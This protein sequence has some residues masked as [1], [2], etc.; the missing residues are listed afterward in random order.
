[1][2]RLTHFSQLLLLRKFLSRN[3]IHSQVKSVRRLSLK[4]HHTFKFSDLSVRLASPDELHSKPDVSE[5]QF[6][7][8]FTDHMLKVAY[9]AS[10]GGWQKP[11]ITP[12]ENLVLH[13]AAKVLHYAIE[14]FEGMKAYRGVDDKIRLFR[15][16]L[17]MRRMNGSAARTSLP[18]FDGDELIRCLCR[19]ILIDQEW[20]PHSEAS[21]LYIRPTIIGIDPTLGVATSTSALLYAIMCPV[22]SY[23]GPDSKAVSLLADPKYTRAWPGG[24]GDK[25]V[26]SNYGPTLQVQAEAA[27]RGMQQ[28]LWLYGEEDY[29]TEVGTMNVFILRLNENGEKELVTP[30][31]D[32]LILPGVT[33]YSIID[34]CKQWP[35]FKVLEERFTMGDLIKLLS[36]NRLLEM[37]GAGTACVVSPIGSILY[38]DVLH[39]IPTVEWEDPLYARLLKTLLDIQYGRVDHPWGVCIDQYC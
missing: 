11:E 21:S 39:K 34:L 25:K 38:K 4:V 14:V 36:E 3:L 27:S 33:R 31:L 18:T 15:P 9:H 30:P 32:G 10:L 24:V 6:G 28:V 1:M 22:G 37:F 23:F 35:E 17:N 5:L 26:G 12:M 7:K 19:L 20:V 13:P 2:A 29:V 8:H 16:D